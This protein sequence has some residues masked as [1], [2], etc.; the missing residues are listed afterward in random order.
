V[1]RS[2]MIALALTLA[3]VWYASTLEEQGGVDDAAPARSSN[4][5]GDADAGTAAASPGPALGAPAAL[6]GQQPVAR[7]LFA[8]H[9]FL[10][11]PPKAAARV[12]VAPP[13]PSAPPLPFRYQGRMTEG[14]HTTVFLTQGERVLIAR[15]GD[16]LNNQYRVESVS[17]GAI[18]FVFEP[19]KQRQTLT[20]GNTK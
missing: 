14:S 19:L 16:L 8:S 15:E 13:P 1:N 3:A 10:P 6:D 2:L 4:G 5:A 17:A 12:D 9:S 20:I 18:T 11:P 7:D